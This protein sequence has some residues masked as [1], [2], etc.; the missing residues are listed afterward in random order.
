MPIQHGIELLLRRDKARRDFESLEKKRSKGDKKVTSKARGSSPTMK[1]IRQHRKIDEDTLL[2]VKQAFSYMKQNPVEAT[3]WYNR[4][5]YALKEGD[6]PLLH[7]KDDVL[8]IWE[9]LERIVT[10]DKIEWVLDN[11][12]LM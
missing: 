4:A 2:L 11:E 3:K 9:Y 8:A 10:I 5:K 12:H 6:A 1:V 7:H